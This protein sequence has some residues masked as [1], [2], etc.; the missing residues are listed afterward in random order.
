MQGLR[1]RRQSDLPRSQEAVA[2]GACSRRS[3]RRFIRA[4]PARCWLTGL[5]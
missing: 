4:L 5:E 3:R 1:E 2:P